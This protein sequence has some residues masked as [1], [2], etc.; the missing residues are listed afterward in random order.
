MP[1]R[2]R[3]ATQAAGLA[4]AVTGDWV[5]PLRAQP[6]DPLAPW[7]VTPRT[8]PRLTALAWAVLA[9]NPHNRQPWLMRLA[10]TETILLHMDLE[11]RLPETDPFDRQLLI[12]LGCFTELLRLAAAERGLA[13]EI[14]PFP[15]GEPQPRLDARPIARI[16]LRGAARPDPLFAAAARRRSAKQPY[17]VTRPVEAAA[18]AT[19]RAALL[20][21]A[22]FGAETGD[23]ARLR[24]LAWRA[25]QVEAQ[26]RA[27][28]METVRLMRFGSAAV[29]ATPDG[30]SLWGPQ[31]DG[32]I[33]AGQL[34]PAAMEPGQPGWRIGFSQYQAIFE[35][36][37]AFTWLVTPGNSRAEQFAAGR[38]WLR[39][40]LA[41]TLHG[42]ALQPVSQALQE[43]PAMAGPYRE[44][45]AL[46]GGGGTV[47][48][49]GRLGHPLRAAPPTPR[50]PV[51]SRILAG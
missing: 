26:D 32:M 49:L 50:W 23:V 37:N 1:S 45:Q 34:T 20:A 19:L 43:F 27:A 15:E 7:A 9:P 47:Q 46:L 5:R 38:D 30:V 41:A 28:W 44:V 11:R 29:A 12:G 36:T 21:P 35:G 10:G 31:M 14:T 39:L 24:D 33:A 8:D 16:T 22:G 3:F 18:I 42:L 51:E 4:L 2:R 25:W 48:M 13:A 40:N 17:D 6:G